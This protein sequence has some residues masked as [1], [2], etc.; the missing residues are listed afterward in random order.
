MIELLGIALLVIVLAPW[1]IRRSKYKEI[2][3]QQ[4][5]RNAMTKLQEKSR[6]I[7]L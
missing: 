5:M 3:R 2:E 4:E 6:R 7:S 1:I